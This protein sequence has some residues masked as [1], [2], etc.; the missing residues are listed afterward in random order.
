MNPVLVFSGTGSNSICPSAKAFTVTLMVSRTTASEVSQSRL[1]GIFETGRRLLEVR[2]KYIDPKTG[3]PRSEEDKGNWSQLIGANQ[4]EGKSMLLFQK[5]YTKRLVRIAESKHRLMPHVALMPTDSLTVDKIGTL[6][7]DR[8]QE[9]L[10][11]G[12]ICP[13]MGRNDRA[14]AV[15]LGAA[16]VKWGGRTSVLAELGHRIF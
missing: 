8:F 5:S 11:D 7:D 10:D 16:G 1:E 3:K 9:L 15:R 14:S 12:T 2:E 6:P 13:N 4:W